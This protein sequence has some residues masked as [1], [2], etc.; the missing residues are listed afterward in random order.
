VPKNPS[1]ASSA[2]NPPYQGATVVITHKVRCDGHADYERWLE[3]I[4][5]QCRAFAGHLDWHIVRPIPG[6]SE[7]Y[8]I[9]IRFDTEAHLRDWMTSP[10]RARL[11]EK[12]QP[13]FV[14]GDDYSVS[15]GLDFWFA[16]AEAKAKLPVRWKQFLIT[17]SAIYPLVLAVPMAVTPILRRLG[18]HDDRYITS[19]A[20]TGI[21]VALMVYVVM[22]RYT[23]LLQRWLSR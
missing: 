6:L 14:G 15:S 21:V 16:P 13:L 2:A 10:T 20:V 8:T 1:E 4:A 11:I 9:I 5:P 17:W 18:A 23:K 19:F 22:P 7:T 3:Q 12:G